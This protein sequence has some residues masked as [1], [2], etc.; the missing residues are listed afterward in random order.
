MSEWEDFCGSMGWA[1][2]EYATD[3]LRNYIDRGHDEEEEEILR[4]NGYKT[5][6]EW[7]AID[8]RVK[9]GEKGIYLPYV[10]IRLFSESQTVESRINNQAHNLTNKRHFQTFEDAILWAK[11]NPGKGITRSPTGEGFI[12]K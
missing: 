3:R 11:S 10:K 6:N 7:N 12:E 1:N 5:V 9:K 8:R 2:D 4:E